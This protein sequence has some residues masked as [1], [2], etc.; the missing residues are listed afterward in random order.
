MYKR[1]AHVVFFATDGLL[2]QK[3]LR[4]ARALASDWVEA[5][6]YAPP[7]ADCDLLIT[8]DAEGL[9]D[10]PPLPQGVRHK[11]WLL[12]AATVDADLEAHIKGLIGG[13]RLLASVDGSPSPPR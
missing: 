9:R 6:S 13:M 10:L 8:L 12:S 11:H 7:L 5:R 3:A 1:R 4:C 2:V